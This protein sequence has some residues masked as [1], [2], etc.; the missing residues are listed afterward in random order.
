MLIAA[1]VV[2]QGRSSTATQVLSSE[3]EYT[4]DENTSDE[5]TTDTGTE[6][7]NGY[8]STVP[9]VTTTVEVTQER[10]STGAQVTSSAVTSWISDEYTS[11][12]GTEQLPLST[13][14]ENI[15]EGNS[16]M[17]TLYNYEK[18]W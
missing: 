13:T 1:L 15:P 9:S 8:S 3:D 4:T 2:T 5:Y 10:S 7:S 14:E 17:Y 11:A 12:T 16:A 6:Q 18:V